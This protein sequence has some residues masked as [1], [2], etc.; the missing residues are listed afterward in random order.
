MDDDEVAKRTKRLREE[1]RRQAAEH[2]RLS[3]ANQGKPQ[4][5][6]SVKLKHA[7]PLAALA[8]AL[9]SLSFHYTKKRNSNRGER[10]L[11]QPDGILTDVRDIFAPEERTGES[12]PQLPELIAGFEPNDGLLLEDDRNNKRW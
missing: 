9:Y 12:G 7:L 5:P 6:L 1:Q 2:E 4:F 8:V 10:D 11:R 3:R